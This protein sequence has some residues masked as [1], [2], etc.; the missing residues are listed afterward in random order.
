MADLSSL[1][2]HLATKLHALEPRIE[3]SESA[4][5]S[6]SAR[7][8]AQLMGHKVGMQAHGRTLEER[9]E[10]AEAKRRAEEEKLETWRR[11]E[12]AKLESRR[13]EEE[14]KLEARQKEEQQRLDAAIARRAEE[15]AAAAAAAE[16]RREE[17]ARIQAKHAEFVEQVQT[18]LAAWKTEHAAEQVRL[19][20]LRAREQRIKERVAVT[21]E[22]LARAPPT[23][24]FD[25]GGRQ[26]AISSAA[27]NDAA[28]ST[29]LARLYFEQVERGSAPKVV[30]DRD[31]THFHLLVDYLRTGE[32]PVV[33]DVSEI[34][35]L[36]REAGYYEVT[37]LVALCRDAY[38]RLDTVK[39]MQ[40]LNGLR[41]L[42]GMD[43]RKLDLSKVDFGSSR[44]AKTSLYFAQLDGANLTKAVLSNCN[45]KFST[46]NDAVATGA[47]FSSSEMHEAQLK[48]ATL[49]GAV[50]SSVKG[51]EADFT[52]A[53]L[54][55]A[56]LSNA[57]LSRAV[58]TS[59]NAA[60]AK[61]PS[62]ADWC[63]AERR[64][65]GA[66]FA[67]PLLRLQERSLDG[68]VLT[69]VNGAKADFTPATLQEAKLSAPCWRAPSRRGRG[70]HVRLGDAEGC[71]AE[72][73]DARRRGA[74][75]GGEMPTSRR[76]GRGARS[77]C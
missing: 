55:K 10:Q 28:G 58:F 12:E 45:L 18:E 7:F 25:V 14:A 37:A 11:E 26:F 47:D 20:E 43:M 35:W 34:Q 74:D 65:A 24:E 13:R 42:S 52:S 5:E 54:Q 17:E 38:K 41:N 59:A 29:L 6:A 66:T 4:F 67:N 57:T 23:I 46:L 15:D 70:R 60:G 53:T 71:E 32:L 1:V 33:A 63:E 69:S 36:E 50:L 31:S 49:D 72:R 62:E 56:K 27:I 48:N 16:R 64:D 21:R 40:L 3:A 39:V 73:R 2:G 30:V 75:L 19:E 22:A 68:A 77:P 44:D 9:A 76:R 61:L 8:D 51:E